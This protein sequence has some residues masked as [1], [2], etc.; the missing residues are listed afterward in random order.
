ME[1]IITF[2]RAAGKGESTNTAGVPANFLP[3]VS[4]NTKPASRN[5]QRR[6]KLSKRVAMSLLQSII[7]K[8]QVEAEVSFALVNLPSNPPSIGIVV[9]DA[10]FCDRCKLFY[11]GPRPAESV[12]DNC[13]PV[14]LKA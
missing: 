10:W 11:D 12:C 3:T 1:K 13:L 14:A 6:K 8:C 2:D 9:K 7:N 5:R 4:E